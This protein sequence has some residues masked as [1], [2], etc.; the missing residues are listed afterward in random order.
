[1]LAAPGKAAGQ[2]VG[3]GMAANES[4]IGLGIGLGPATLRLRNLAL[5]QQL[6]PDVCLHGFWR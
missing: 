5:R 2:L 3:F 4:G 6:G 1:M